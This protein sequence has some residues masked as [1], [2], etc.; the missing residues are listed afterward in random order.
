MFDDIIY[1]FD[2]T[3]F[4]SYPV[5]VK[6]LKMMLDDD[7]IEFDYDTAYEK[8]K[9]NIGTALKYY[10]PND[11]IIEKRNEFWNKYDLI[12]LDEQKLM[13]F[14][15]EIL[16]YAL[17][18]GKRNYIYTHSGKVV[19]ALLDKFKIADK[20]TFVLDNS[21]G[22]ASKPDPSALNWLKE[23][24]SLVPERCLMVGDRDI[25]IF[26]GHNA[27]I[28]G[29]LYDPE[30]LYTDAIADFNIDCLSGLKEII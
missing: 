14:A 26:V 21:M 7:G 25:D 12:Y 2:G 16:D 24:C 11:D 29:C 22:F 3:L 10:Y 13:P 18:K 8:L 27:G 20:F 23:K 17:E 6:S 15:C 9:V 19:Y 5:F 30:H 1:D 28:K 4:D